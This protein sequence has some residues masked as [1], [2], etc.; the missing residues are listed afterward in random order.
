MSE[1]TTR[2]LLVR[3]GEHDARG[4]FLQHACKGLTPNGADQARALAHRLSTRREWNVD[5]VLVSNAARSVE[6][7]QI[8][9]RE[10][11]V[12]VFPPSCD[13]CE[14]HP[15][16]AEGMTAQEATARWGT[17]S[18]SAI[19][20]A[21]AYEDR[22]IRARDALI[23]IADRHRGQTVVC[24]THSAL[25]KASFELL[26]GMPRA[27]STSTQTVTNTAVTEWTTGAGGERWSEGDA[28]TWRLGR[29]NDTSHLFMLDVG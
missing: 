13:L 3:H 6:S 24:V 16:D 23:G 2:L 4:R 25:V 26:G 21:E 8:L 22:L 9:G 1:G 15:G 17:A 5:A 18:Y 12:E 11:G 28:Q 7:G 14:M 19:P 20:G 27:E 29:H 10:L